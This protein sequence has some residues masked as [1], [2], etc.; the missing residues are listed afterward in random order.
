MSDYVTFRLDGRDYATRIDAVR[1]VVRLAELVALPG[2]VAPLAGV[3]DL[4]GASLPVVDIRTD[5]LGSRGDVLVLTTD[6]ADYGF[7]CDAVTA[8]VDRAALPVESS[9]VSDSG[10]MPQYVERVLR[11]ADGPVFLVDLAKMAGDS[12]SLALSSTA[13]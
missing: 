2:M 5:R 1:E 7:A 3:L 10:A 13:P 4:R 9:R 12:A 8:V 11:G 6:T